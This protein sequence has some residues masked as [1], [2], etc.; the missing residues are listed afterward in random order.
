MYPQFPDGTGITGRIPGITGRNDGAGFECVPPSF[1][2][3]PSSLCLECQP[4]G[5]F[6][7]FFKCLS[8]DDETRGPV[9]LV[10]ERMIPLQVSWA[11]EGLAGEPPPAG[12][13]LWAPGGLWQ[14]QPRLCQAL[15]S[16]EWSQCVFLRSKIRSSHCGLAG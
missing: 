12:S 2:F 6:P 15:S 10:L 16:K 1:R 11:T 8:F 4:R 13:Q 5:H 14:N 7:S 3:C 9:C